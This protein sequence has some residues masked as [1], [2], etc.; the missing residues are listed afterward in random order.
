MLIDKSFGGTSPCNAL[1]AD[2]QISA[3]SVVVISFTGNSAFACMADDAGGF[4]QG[5]ALVAKYRA[6]VTA[7][8]AI[9]H[10]AGARTL[11]VGQ[12][13]RAATDPANDLVTAI[14][15]MYAELA[16]SSHVAFVDAGASVEN[17]DGTFALGLPCVP[18][19][20]ECGSDGTNVVRND[21][22]VHF[23]PG[24]P[25]QTVDCPVY[26]S[27]AFRFANSIATAA[28]RL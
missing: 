10:T 25:T 17:P 20:Q 14:N 1:E 7:L 11:L 28:H 12:P 3:G 6:D 24:P 18:G 5:D 15:R 19:E 26:S 22:G 21:D 8:I 16:H 4:L 13:A 9:A 2:L 23:C 27:G